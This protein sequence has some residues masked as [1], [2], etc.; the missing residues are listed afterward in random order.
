M[1]VAQVFIYNIR[2]G[3]LEEFMGL[4]KRA[5]K[6]IRPLGAS[7]RTLNVVAGGPAPGACIYLIETPSWKAFGEFSAK[8]D[9]DPAWQKFLAD[10]NSTDKPTA[11]LL[12]SSVY[13]EIPVG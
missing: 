10:V 9:S 11:D 5:D 1:A 13:S 3:A 8:L 7:T 4:A 12:S 2:P 6:I